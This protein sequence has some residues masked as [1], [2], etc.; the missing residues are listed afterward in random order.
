MTW[1]CRLFNLKCSFDYYTTRLLGFFHLNTDQRNDWNAK[2]F[3]LCSLNLRSRANSYFLAK[4]MRICK[5]RKDYTT[6]PK[7]NTFLYQSFPNRILLTCRRSGLLTESNKL[8]YYRKCVKWIIYLL[9]RSPGYILFIVI[10]ITAG[11]RQLTQ[12]TII[13]A[14]IL[15]YGTKQYFENIQLQITRPTV[16][17]SL[18]MV[19]T[20]IS[21]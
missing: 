2:L 3:T 1:Q 7:Q 15:P 21:V 13:D 4:P 10:D 12:Y 11:K 14:N 17:Y 19:S 9:E 18:S 8:Y 16:D 6:C 20:H 5:Q